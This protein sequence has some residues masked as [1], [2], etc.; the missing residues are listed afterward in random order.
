MKIG[1]SIRWLVLVLCIFSTTIHPSIAI[2]SHF[3][4]KSLP[5]ILI[6]ALHY[7]GHESNDDEAVQIVNTTDADIILDSTWELIDQGNH[8]LKF[9]RAVLPA[10][11]HAWI[12]NDPEAFQRQFGDPPA[13]SYEQMSGANLLFSNSGGSVRLINNGEIVDTLVYG[14]GA[15]QSDW[16]GPAVQP[17]VI[18]RSVA[19][20]G[21]ILMRKFPFIDSN[22]AQDWLSD[23]I[24]P[25]T[26]RKMAFP[27]WKLESF[28]QP[29]TDHAAISVA[30]APD[31]SYE[32][33]RNLLSSATTSID[34]ESYSFDNSSLAEILRNK[35]SAGVRVRVLLDGAP[36]GGISDETRYACQ[37]I[38][39]TDDTDSGCWF[40]RSDSASKTHARYK[41]LHAKFVIIDDKMLVV[42]SENF[43]LNG[44][45]ADDKADGTQGH[46]GLLAFTQAPNLVAR[47][48]AIFEADFRPNHRDIT[49]WCAT[50]SPYGGPSTQ[51]TL[52]PPQNGIRYSVRYPQAIHSSRSVPLELATSPESNLRDGGLLGL[53]AQAGAGDE[54]LVQQL[55]E[56]TYWGE[57]TSNPKSDPNMRIEGVIGAAS[58][59]ADVR[60]LLDGH[61]D[62]AGVRSNI[63]TTLYLN[64]IAQQFGWN[65]R[66]GRGNPTGNG[67]HNKLYMVRIGLRKFVQL[68]S[69]NGSEV[70]AKRNREMTIL[71]ESEEI[72]DYL[73]DMFMGDFWQS[74][75]IF[76]PLAL[77]NVAPPNIAQHLLIS[78]VMIDPVGLDAGREWIEVYNPTEQAID[79][80]NYKIGDAESAGRIS[81][82]GMFVFP[83]GSVIG[84][85]SVMVVAQSALAYFEDHGQKPTFE[86][87]NYDPDV[88]DLLPYTPWSTGSISLSNTGDQV[89]LLNANDGIVDVVQWLST[90]VAGTI[91]FSATLNSGHSLQRWPYQLDTDNCDAD[92]RPQAIPSPGKVP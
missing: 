28:A 59:G 89:L 5:P 58:R 42:S 71:I 47:A 2:Q 37:R 24:N 20:D 65:M 26:G 52:K 56:P 15:A 35:A 55:D 91:P 41:E 61:Y 18:P 10:R 79:I 75:A 12:A 51:F 83:A 62:R 85:N 64:T 57:A 32:T 43:G 73:R 16:N 4:N 48:R 7:W 25:L 86:L 76:L 27:G 3:H 17:Y 54:I 33:L 19:A 23:P 44:Y 92:F 31:A 1:F 77:N 68:G 82:D 88:P 84:P 67:I 13:L 90:A 69:W 70:S 40:M 66:A 30:V 49:R 21:Q 22:T 60:V 81:N 8:R 46:R 14:N 9:P 36:S 87:G 74:Q 6:S 50:C 38:S 34:I 45:P 72:Y 78:E 29:A 63:S 80:S 11:Q 39:T 53:L